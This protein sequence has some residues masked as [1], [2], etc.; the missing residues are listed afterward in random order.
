MTDRQPPP[1]PDEDDR[2]VL[3]PHLSPASQG[4]RSASA[5]AVDTTSHALP[6]GTRLHEFEV[7]SL[8]GVGGFGIVYV[9]FD[10]SLKREVAVKEYMPSSL[11][12]RKADAITVVIRSAHEAPT[13]DI[14]LRSF[15]NEAQLLAQFD[16]PAL[17][18]V[19][20]FWEANGTAYMAMPWYRGQT[21]HKLLAARDSAPDEAW[22]LAL[23]QP[24]LGALEVM[25]AAQCFHRDIAP[26]NIMLQPDGRPVLLD[27]GAARRVISGMTQALTVI[28]KAGY[29][30]IEQYADAPGAQQGPWTDLYALGAVVHQMITGRTPPPSVARLLNDTLQPLS[31][32]A[33]G[34]YSAPF[35]RAIDCC[36]CV[37]SEGRPQSVAQLRAML[38][39][40]QPQ[41]ARTP[42][43]R[44][45]SDSDDQRTRILPLAALG[46]AAST[47]AADRPRSHAGPI[48]AAGVAALLLIGAGAA[49]LAIRRAD[50]PLAATPISNAPPALVV[51]PVSPPLATPA[52]PPDP[53]VT[54][55]PDTAAAS[56]VAPPIDTVRKP[57]P[58][59]AVAK[60]QPKREPRATDAPA[61]TPP[62]SA[63]VEE[64]E[65]K[66]V[67]ELNKKLDSLLEDKP[68]K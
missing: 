10:H 9:A 66:Y 5:A 29:A 14:G 36:L 51:A 25:H 32:A 49:W 34:R 39:E 12:S 24:L 17:L 15:I 16:H 59:T 44:A 23:L 26:D 68:K 38:A 13:F 62:R 35:L 2:T 31:S 30:P 4:S 50:S 47:S 53:V 11:A 7:T 46:G 56:A 63:A 6:I 41:P 55:A 3:D 43:A 28:L 33:Q 52:P 1:P 19:F 64:A 45:P 54:A 40:A 48:V 22:I 61:T 58:T 21:L 8:L 20:R 67:E 27:L 18:K 37:K 42:P 57:P 65:R 60:P